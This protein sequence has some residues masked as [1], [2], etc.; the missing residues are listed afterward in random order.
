MD[1]YAM[2]MGMV[3]KVV[4]FY[5]DSQKRPLFSMSFENFKNIG[6]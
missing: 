3:S 4:N 6:K 2:Q 5:N 1:G